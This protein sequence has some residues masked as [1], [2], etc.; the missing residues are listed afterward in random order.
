MNEKINDIAY[1]KYKL[2]TLKARRT[3]SNERVILTIMSTFF[4]FQRSTYAPA[5]TPN[6]MDGTIIV[7]TTPELAVLE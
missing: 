2:F 1:K 7:R 5:S 4:L 6:I 3:R